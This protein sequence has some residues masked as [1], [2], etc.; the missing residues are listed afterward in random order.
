MIVCS[1]PKVRSR[2]LNTT[3][4]VSTDTG[5]PNAPPIYFVGYAQQTWANRAAGTGI[6]KPAAA[7]DTQS[8]FTLTTL[9]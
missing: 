1:G 2:Y 7:A 4:F 6:A 9:V 3:Q 8:T 5:G